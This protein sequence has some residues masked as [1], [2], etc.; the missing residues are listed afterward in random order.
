VELRPPWECTFVHLITLFLWLCGT[1]TLISVSSRTHHCLLSWVRRIQSTSSHY[2]SLR[3]FL[4]I[5]PLHAYTCRVYS[6]RTC[7]RAFSFIL[8]RICQL[9]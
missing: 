8:C 1:L 2:I 7:C 6:D 3:S 5:P 4:I 9:V